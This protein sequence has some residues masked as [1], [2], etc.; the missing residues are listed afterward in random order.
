MLVEGHNGRL[1]TVG[2]LPSANRDQQVREAFAARPQYQNRSMR[3]AWCA[4]CSS[5]MSG[6][7]FRSRPKIAFFNSSPRQ[8]RM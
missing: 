6:D 4:W 7:G 5:L 8:W 2:Q 1:R 3:N